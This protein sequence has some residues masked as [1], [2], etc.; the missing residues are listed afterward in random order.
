MAERI[1]D[2]ARADKVLQQLLTRWG[3]PDT[4]KGLREF[5]DRLADAAGD[6]VALVKPQSAFFERHGPD[7][8]KVLQHVMK[9][10]REAGSLTLLDVKLP[11]LA[12]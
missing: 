11:R 2:T 7:G 5:C 4:A 12:F 3:L 6:T 8:L 10:F 1:E 9:R